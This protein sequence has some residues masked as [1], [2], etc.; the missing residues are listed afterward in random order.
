MAYPGSP[1]IAAQLLRHGDRMTLAELHPQEHAALAGLMGARARVEKR[2]G[3]E[4]AQALCPPQPRRGV[5]MIDPSYEV[6]SDYGRVP[7]F[8]ATIHRKWN[9][10]V[11]LLWYPILEAGAHAPMVAQ[12]RAAH[13]EAQLHEARFPPIR[14]GHRMIGTGLAVLN[15][16]YG[17]AEEAARIRALMGAA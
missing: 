5:L 16:P 11:I 9:V 2:C 7:K 12:I 8:I 13:P 10:G 17:L 15:A 4:L 6:K 14:D 3:F 1:L